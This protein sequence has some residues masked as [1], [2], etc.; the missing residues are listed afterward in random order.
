MRAPQ[1]EQT[2]ALRRSLLA[3]RERILAHAR[4]DIAQLN[5]HPLSEIAGDVP[6]EGDASVAATVS[7]FE[8]AMIRRELAQVHDIDSTLQ[9]MEEREFGLCSDCGEPIAKARL[10]AF[11]TATRCIECQRLHERMYAHAAM[12]TL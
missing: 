11:P 5:Q 12:P 1:R 8:S 9:R 6:D 4:A 2:Q 7:A 10:K 3:E